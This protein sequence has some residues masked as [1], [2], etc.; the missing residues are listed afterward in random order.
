MYPR[1]STGNRTYILVVSAAVAGAVEFNSRRVLHVCEHAKQTHRLFTN[2]NKKI[3]FEYLHLMGTRHFTH[4]FFPTVRECG[5]RWA[6]RNINKP[7][8]IYPTYFNIARIA[9][10]ILFVNS[11]CMHE[12]Q[13]CLRSA[14]M[15]PAPI[16]NS[17]TKEQDVEWKNNSNVN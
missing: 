1:C 9:K 5:V 12:T 14:R 3:Q 4:I 8:K 10:Y 7:N 2:K 6:Q 17:K 16:H 15:L 13:L 11:L